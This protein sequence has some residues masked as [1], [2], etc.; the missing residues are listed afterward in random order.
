MTRTWLAA[1]VL[2]SSLHVVGG[3]AARASE[4]PPVQPRGADPAPAALTD[5]DRAEIARRVA[6]AFDRAVEEHAAAEAVEQLKAFFARA[7]GPA[8]QTPR[9]ADDAAPKP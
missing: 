5:E 8:E 1:A 2:L 9:P 3:A 4:Q 7:A 6:A